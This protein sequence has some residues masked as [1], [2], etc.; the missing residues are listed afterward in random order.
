MV[1]VTVSDVPRRTCCGV[2]SELPSAAGTPTRTMNGSLAAVEAMVDTSDPMSRP[3]WTMWTVPVSGTK[4]GA[5]A[6]IVASPNP[7]P[8]I[9]WIQ[10]VNDTSPGF[11]GM[12]MNAEPSAVEVADSRIIAGLLLVS[13]TVTPP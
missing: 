2:D 1:T 5:V 4:P 12:S 10:Y 13:R 3:G 7:A 11:M 6:V 8:S 9:P